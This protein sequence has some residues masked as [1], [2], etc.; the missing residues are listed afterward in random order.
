MRVVIKGGYYFLSSIIVILALAFCIIEGRLLFSGDWMLYEF[1]F[2][3]ALRYICRLLMAVAAFGIGILPFINIK[4]KCNKL[5]QVQRLG[6]VMLFSMA[7][8]VLVFATNY[9]GMVIFIVAGVYFVLSQY[10]D[11]RGIFS[12]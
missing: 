3:G 6:A 9:V 10:I 1:A 5:L 7:A 12:V 4:K 8:I 2:G 11:I